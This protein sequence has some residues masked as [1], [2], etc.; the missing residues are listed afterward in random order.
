M[1]AAFSQ[2]ARKQSQRFCCFS[3]SCYTFSVSKTSSFSTAGALIIY[4]LINK[5]KCVSIVTRAKIKSY[6]RSEEA[7]G[8]RTHPPRHH[9]SAYFEHILQNAVHC[10]CSEITQT[11]RNYTKKI[12]QISRY[13]SAQVNQ[14]WVVKGL[15]PC[16]DVGTRGKVM[17]HNLRIDYSRDKI[18]PPL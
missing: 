6:R 2:I 18:L 8:A 7:K 14:I 1:F 12:T 9:S 11:H 17:L 4:H 15:F 16:T 5:K 13:F 3:L 10:W